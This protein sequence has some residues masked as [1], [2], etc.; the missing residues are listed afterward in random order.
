MKKFIE[1]LFL[2]FLFLIGC[3][4]DAI[5]EADDPVDPDSYNP[6]PEPKPLIVPPSGLVLC[7][8]GL[9]GDY[10]CLGY[11]LQSIVSLSVM[12]ATAG[13]DSWG[14]TDSQSGKEY[15]LMGLDNGTAFIDISKPDQ[16]VF[17]G[18]LN[19]A[20][21]SSIW[22]DIKVFQDHAFIVS[23]AQ[24]HGLQVFDLTRLRDITEEQKFTADV[25]MTGF[26]NAHNIAINEVSGYAYVVGSDLYQGGPAFIDINDPTNPTLVGGFGDESYTHDAHIITYE[27]PD[28]EYQGKEIL[29]GSN[30]DGGEN[31]QLI[32][33]DVS[34]KTAPKLISNIT[35]SSG[36]YT[37]QGW[38]AEDF[39]YF[40]LGDELDE[41][42]YGNL[43]KTLVFD[44]E[45]L[46]NP[47]LHH[48][49]L[50]T[51]AAIDHNGY[52]RGDSFFL[53]NYTAGFREIDIQ[54]IGSREMEEVGFFDTFPNHDNPTFDAVWN[55]YPYFESGVIVISDSNSGLFLVKAS[56]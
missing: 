20:S 55:V 2:S 26:G 43:S 56:Q 46:D 15:V 45:D 28:T 9:A 18:K 38:L 6:V 8:G 40:Y 14:W 41:Y 30:S 53:A 4:K 47:I 44:L 36:G 37:H 29:F 1:L 48:T 54:N 7:N 39:R 23:E 11:D 5:K 17:L 27:G 33:V 49:Y 52:T 25:R 3:S 35:Y 16:P 19:S 12:G 42:Q 21:V 50:G 51:T 34:D 22:R 31:N 13:N 32:I 24:N 10:P